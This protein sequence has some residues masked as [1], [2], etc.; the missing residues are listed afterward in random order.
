MIKS[1]SVFIHY[2]AQ[3]IWVPLLSMPFIKIALI[4]SGQVHTE[5]DSISTPPQTGESASCSQFVKRILP[6]L[7][8][9]FYKT[10]YCWE[11][12]A[13]VC[14]ISICVPLLKRRIIK[15]KTNSRTISYLSG[16]IR[17]LHQWGTMAQDYYILSRIIIRRE[18]NGKNLR[19]ALNQNCL[20]YTSPSPRDMRRSRMPSSA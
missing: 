14:I 8:S 18:F 9:P 12:Q 11:P 1:K 2:P 20:L 6:S 10:K 15:A 3:N 5:K 7:L 13:T 4:T 17:I 16:K 19:Q